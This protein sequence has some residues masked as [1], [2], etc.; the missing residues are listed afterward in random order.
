MKCASRGT[1]DIYNGANTS[2]ARKV[3]PVD[4]VSVATRKLSYLGAA[5]TVSDLRVPPG[6]RLEALSG[7][8]AVQRSIR[9]NDQ[10][11]SCFTWTGAG[12]I[13]VETSIS[14]QRRARVSLF[15]VV[16]SFL[17]AAGAHEKGP[18]RRVPCSGVVRPPEGG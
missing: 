15:G 11:R 4:L 2:A 9:I 8:R 14:A 17:R 18:R 3:L 12:P 7:D 6:N 13:D 16:H 5:G 10:Y 1:E